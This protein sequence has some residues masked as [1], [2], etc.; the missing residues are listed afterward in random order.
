MGTGFDDRTLTDLRARLT[1]RKR[2]SSPLAAPPDD[3]SIHW[4]TPDLVAE[5][6]FTEWTG[7]DRLRH[8]RFLG[9]RDD[10]PAT[11][12]CRERPAR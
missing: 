12:V 3:D 9:P 11:D 5:I 2:D 1:K 10:K 6:G 8:P 7:D 4:V